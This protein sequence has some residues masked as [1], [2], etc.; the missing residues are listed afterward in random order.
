M[1]SLGLL[2]YPLHHSLSPIIHGAALEYC[3]LEGNYSLFP[4]PPDDA[5]EIQSL[6]DRIRDGEITGLNIT[7]PY[8]QQIIS[9][10]DEITPTTKAIGAVNTIF[11][12][13]GKLVGDNTDAPGFLLDLDNLLNGKLETSGNSKC[14]LVLGAGGAAC[15]V[16]YA[17]ITEGWKVMVAARRQEQAQKLIAQFSNHSSNLHSIDFR[18]EAFKR[19]YSDLQLIVNTTPVGMSPNVDHSLWPSGAPFPPQA[20]IYDL[21]YNPRETKFVKDA[22]KAGLSAVTGIGMLVEQAALSFEIW[23]GKNIPRDILLDSMEEK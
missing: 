1:I 2:G 4:I 10:L 3:G 19:M 8:K 7:I 15:A 6:V 20:A 13:N 21:V 11:M 5:N 9:C 16:T 12:Q 23:T 14:A 22:R 18:L 17:L